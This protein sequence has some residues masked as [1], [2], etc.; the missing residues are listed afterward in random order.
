MDRRKLIQLAALTPFLTAALALGCKSAAPGAKPAPPPP[1]SQAPADTS[2]A[3]STAGRQLRYNFDMDQPANQDFAFTDDAI[4]IYVRPFE[5]NLSMKVQGR[6]QNKVKIY[7]D[8]SEFVDILGRRYQLVPPSVTIKQ[9]AFGNVP[10]TELAPGQLFTGKV[11]L[12]DPAD[13]QTIRALGGE[14][15]PVVPPDAGTPEQIRG[16]EFTMRLVLELNYE[17]KSYDFSF[18]IRDIFYR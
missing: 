1:A 17:R 13:I 16:R 14:P 9:A 8:E 15:S 10:P 3:G 12:L 4:F 18:T 7:W 2:G 5:D 11:L 6:V